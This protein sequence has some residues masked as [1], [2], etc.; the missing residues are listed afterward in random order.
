VTGSR[1]NAD[2][3]VALRDWV[4]RYLARLL[5]LD[6]QHIDLNKSLGEFGLDSVDAMIMAGELEE[7]FGIET[8]PS[9]FFECDTA[10]E[11]LDAWGRSRRSA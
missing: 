10:Q 8:D 2:D 11:L 4:V 6:E 1:T 5:E 9:I 3:P 7:H